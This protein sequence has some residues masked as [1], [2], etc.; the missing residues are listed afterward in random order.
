[1]RYEFHPEALQE[2]DEAA[3]YYTEQQPDLD[4]RFIQSV[5]HAIQ[6]HRDAEFWG[7]HALRVLAIAPS[8]SRT[9]TARADKN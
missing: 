8:R 3:H 4:L 6:S 9:L 7:A 5:E 2:Y 1:M